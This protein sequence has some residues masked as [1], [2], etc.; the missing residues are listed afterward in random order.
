MRRGSTFVVEQEE[1]E[2]PP[3]CILRVHSR[4]RVLW[5]IWIVGLAL[6]TVSVTPMKVAFGMDQPALGVF[7]VSWV[8]DACF[9]LDIALNFATSFINAEGEE[10]LQR[11]GIAA[12]YIRGSA[13][14]LDLVA[15]VPQMPGIPPWLEVL[16]LLKLVRMRRLPGLL[17]R[18]NMT[19]WARIV[20]RL[21]SLTALLLLIYH[22]IACFWVLV[23][24]WGQRAWIP[25]VNWVDAARLRFRYFEEAVSTQYLIALYSSQ[26]ALNSGEIGPRSTGELLAASAII[27]LGM[28][29]NALLFGTMSELLFSLRKAELESQRHIDSANTLMAQI[30]LPPRQRARVVEHLRSTE[31]TFH[32]QQQLTRFTQQIPPTLRF[33]VRRHLYTA[34]LARS[35]LLR[36]LQ[37]AEAGQLEQLVGRFETVLSEPEERVVEWGDPSEAMFWVA[38][39]RACVLRRDLA[40]GGFKRLKILSEGEHFGEVGLLYN[41]PRTMAVETHKYSILARLA[42][43]DFSTFIY[44]HPDVFYPAVFAYADPLKRVLA[45]TLSRLPLCRGLDSKELHRVLF[46]F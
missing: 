21:W 31:S 9:I 20:V 41:C 39:G 38:R 4:P 44:S 40:E 2:R 33:E 46:A 36:G 16:G 27:F 18:V 14:W 8:A 32:L 23:V 43:S 1:R 10:V 5:D 13:F 6:W 37:G 25:P 3:R 24:G 29:V 34:M 17:N 11:R 35:R 19:S 45:R 42:R 22:L 12:H 15:G 30:A 7:I 28:F 26:L